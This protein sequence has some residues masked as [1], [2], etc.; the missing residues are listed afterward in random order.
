LFAWLLEFLIS[1]SNW[2]REA[3]L[4][5]HNTHFSVFKKKDERRKKKKKTKM[6][7]TAKR[8][9]CI[10]PK[11]LSPELVSV[12]MAL[13]AQ[14]T[15]S[16]NLPNEVPATSNSKDFI[17][18]GNGL[19]VIKKGFF[20]SPLK[21]GHRTLSYYNTL[22]YPTHLLTISLWHSIRKRQEEGQGRQEG[23]ERRQGS[24]GFEV[25]HHSRVPMHALS[26]DIRAVAKSTLRASVQC[27]TH[28][29]SQL[30]QRRTRKHHRCS[31]EPQRYLLLKRTKQ[32]FF[33]SPR[34]VFSFHLR[35]H[36]TPQV[37][38]S[39]STIPPQTTLT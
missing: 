21:S 22:C 20:S 34:N 24:V 17:N 13:S 19:A 29:R 32:P 23:E 15:L 31:C 28:S 8:L 26:N 37:G 9:V 36:Q 39:C 12:V 7:P 6:E 3:F 10:N 11:M 35:N 14:A 38:S 4:Y 27:G 25:G 16:G 33:V 30:R 1:I 2:R 5:A 18:G